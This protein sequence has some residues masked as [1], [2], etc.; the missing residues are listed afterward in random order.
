MMPSPATWVRARTSPRGCAAAVLL[1]VALIGG[2]GPAAAAE[3]FPADTGAALVRWVRLNLQGRAK[4]LEPPEPLRAKPPAPVLAACYRQGALVATGVRQQGTYAETGAALA[5]DLLRRLGKPKTLADIV[6]VV[7]LQTTRR[8][9]TLAPDAAPALRWGAEGLAVSLAGGRRL[10]SRFAVARCRPKAGLLPA[11]CEL[12]GE[13]APPRTGGAGPLQ[14]EAFR[15]VAFAERRPGGPVARVCL[16]EEG[17][18]AVAP[19][20][21]TRAVVA[22]GAW[23]LRMRDDKGRLAAGY[24]PLRK[25]PLAG[26]DLASELEAAQAFLTL[27]RVLGDRDLRRAADA[28]IAV[29]RKNQKE[30]GGA[31]VASYV[32]HGERGDLLPTVAFLEA[33]CLRAEVLGEG[34]EDEETARLGRFVLDMI[35][36][37]GRVYQRLV[38]KVANETPLPNVDGAAER[39]AAV[40]CRLAALRPAAERGEWLG[41]AQRI[42]FGLQRTRPASSPRPASRGVVNRLKGLLRSR[43]GAGKR[44]D[45]RLVQALAALYRAT[46]SK[47]VA[48]QCLRAADDL[49]PPAAE[50]S[51]REAALLL[52][53]RLAAQQIAAERAL[54]DR[55]DRKRVEREAALL[56]ARQFRAESAFFLPDPD[57]AQGGFTATASDWRLRVDTCASAVRALAAAA[58]WLDA[59]PGR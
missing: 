5:T 54:P 2:I 28:V 47:A 46:P 17:P 43:R 37:D 13:K 51:T 39:A 35:R 18:A 33:L 21:L 14:V 30:A 15:S 40:L 24:D 53:A 36:P 3:D 20:T 7:E 34:A 58:A 1:A 57:R 49:P 32:S 27:Y 45:P 16:G 48:R 50:S 23:L 25:Q 4:G 55:A 26:K 8:T 52:A 44:G 12:T 31:I 9:L 56:W 42:L 11:L 41:G 19:R 38:R 29:A 59:P 22:G 10:F 6:L